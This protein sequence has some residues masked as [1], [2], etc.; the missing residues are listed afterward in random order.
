MCKPGKSELLGHLTPHRRVVAGLGFHQAAHILLRG[1][2]GEEVADRATE[3]VVFGGKRETHGAASLVVGRPESS[4]GGHGRYNTINVLYVS[5]NRV[6][7]NRRG[8]HVEMSTD[9]IDEVKTWLSENWDP[10]LTVGQWWERL[11]MAGWSA[12]NF[13]AEWYGHGAS[14]ADNAEIQRTI[15]EFGAVGTTRRFGSAARRA[16]PS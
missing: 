12:P 7:G 11:G 6:Q 4:A 14:G 13:P 8:R 10:D 16:R 15:R 3:F 1:L 2:R 5:R 9:Y